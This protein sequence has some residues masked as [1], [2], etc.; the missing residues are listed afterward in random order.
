VSYNHFK[1]AIICGGPSLERGISLNSARSLLDHLSNQPIDID[2]IYVDRTLT[3][4]RL[5]LAQI[6]SNTPADF[7]F[8]LKESGSKIPLDK[9]EHFFQQFDLIF[10][11]IHGTFGE[12][13][14]L[15]AQLEAYGIPFVG[16]SSTAC[17]QLFYKHRAAR[18]LLSHGFG[19]SPAAVLQQ[20]NTHTAAIIHRFF[21]TYQP[22]RA[23]I[24]PVAGGSSIG[25]SSV[26]DPQQA[27]EKAQAL[28]DAGVDDRLL[29]EPFIEGKE[30]TV[31]VL[32]LENGQPLALWPSQIAVSY[33]ADGIF[34]YRRKYLPSS[35]TQYYTPACFDQETI[36]TIR[37]EAE[38]IFRLF[39][40]ADFARI[41]GWLLDDGRLLF[42]DINPI[43]GMEQ[44]SF[45]FRQASLLG[46]SHTQT[47]AFILQSAC[48][49]YGIKPPQWL[50]SKPEK[51]P[52]RLVYVLMGGQTA[53]RQVSLMS[54]THVWLKLQQ[55]QRYRP[56]PF[57]L[58]K[59][60][61]VWPLA[62]H[63]A[64]HHT[65]EEVF[66]SLQ[67]CDI[68]KIKQLGQAIYDQAGWGNY[69]LGP[70]SSKMTLEAWTQKAQADQAFVFI[71]LH[72]GM[73]ENGEL[74]RQLE[75]A[76]LSFNGSPSWVCERC[77]DKYMTGD[78]IN[79]ANISGL[80]S[81]PK[82]TYHYD[83]LINQKDNLWDC[84]VSDLRSE[85]LIMKPRYDGCSA[86]VAILREKN[87]LIT[88]IQYLLD[89]LDYIPAYTFANQAY[90]IEL[91]VC[92]QTH[93]MFEPYIAVDALVVS[94]QSVT[95]D[96]F[97]RTGWLELTIGVLED[98]GQYEA[99]VPSITVA[100]AGVLSLEE[101][102]Q[103]GTGINFT[104]PPLSLLSQLDIAII[105]AKAVGAAQTLG[106]R[107]YARL[108]IF[109]H[110][111]DQKVV[112]IECNNLP[113]LTPST[114]IYHQA[115]AHTPSMNPLCFIEHLIDRALNRSD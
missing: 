56:I 6:Y 96:P 46:F 77:V 17:Q 93:Y 81:L 11:V 24:K 92:K 73:G 72:G 28:F 76:N 97:K 12:T 33:Q 103:G 51:T 100:H 114:V 67:P 85:V 84:L 35:N 3:F 54:G 13:G 59:D 65:T 71:A 68:D 115:F 104:P 41:D 39:E 107:N 23:I 53:E 31:L 106:I 61:W 82:V 75:S 49:R 99:L 57:F 55:S 69:Q 29:L 91:P 32:Q 7:D 25:V 79:Q 62:Y 37:H 58:D 26:Y 47:L 15:Q 38:S 112:L 40:M 66:D 113:A 19:V 83:D 109:Y 111:A 5:S 9:L 18:I 45:V 1:L 22:K 89:G 43:T 21:R 105:Q 95:Y 70:L 42:T 16:S 101:K 60:G 63:Q 50:P 14:E 4:H 36:H 110:A 8:K 98:Q 88:Y 108:D 78:A 80:M 2:P 20:N 27:L 102:F 86:G 74:Q 87:D 44:N 30:F 94:E 90:P 52:K 10:P 34:D 64:I 48:Q